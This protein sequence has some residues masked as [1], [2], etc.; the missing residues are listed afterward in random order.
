MKSSDRIYLGIIDGGTVEGAFAAD[1]FAFGISRAKRIEGIVRVEGNLLSR[2]RNRVVEYFLERTRAPWLMMLDTDH[3]LP[4]AALDRLVDSAHEVSVPVVSGLTFAAYLPG[5]GDLY[6]RPVPT[7]YRRIG[8]QYAPI[9]H[10]PADQLIEVDAA[11]TGCLLVHRSALETLRERRPDGIGA[12]WAWF[13]DGPV[14]DDWYSEDLAMMLRLEATGI[15]IHAHTGAIFPHLK[16]YT[17]TE[18]HYARHLE[19]SSH[20]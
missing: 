3:R 12:A 11:G 18:A 17:L 10:Y 19:E 15:P 16:T 6:P 9:E 7:I 1:L 20:E 2:S 8:A 5:P 14:G 4:V 13:A